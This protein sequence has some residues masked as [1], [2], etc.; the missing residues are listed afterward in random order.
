MFRK[1]LT[2]ILNI[3]NAIAFISAAVGLLFG[4]VKYLI[5]IL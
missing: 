3:F 2:I 4:I 1:T 5:L